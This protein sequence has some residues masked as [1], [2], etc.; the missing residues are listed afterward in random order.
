MTSPK[1][2]VTM[3]TSERSWGV[4]AKWLGWRRF[5]GIALIL[6]VMAPAV[7]IFLCGWQ[8]GLGKILKTTESNSYASE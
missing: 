8:I 4:V 5:I 2:S 1:W 3:T 6:N 7:T